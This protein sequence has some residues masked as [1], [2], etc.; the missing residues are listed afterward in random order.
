MAGTLQKGSN[1]IYLFEP[2]GKTCNLPIYEKYP[3]LCRNIGW[4]GVNYEKEQQ[5][6]RSN[7][8]ETKG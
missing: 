4:E 8:Q 7:S 2:E 5:S 6:V 1:S 3:E